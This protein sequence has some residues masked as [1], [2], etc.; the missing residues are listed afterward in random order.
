[1]KLKLLL[2][3]IVVGG[4]LFWAFSHDPQTIVDTPEENDVLPEEKKETYTEYIVQDDDTFT[5]AMEALGFGYSEALAMVSSSADVYDFTKIRIGKPFRLYTKDGEKIRLEYDVNTEEF[6]SVDVTSDDFVAVK[7]EIAYDVSDVHKKATINNSLYVSGLDAG[8]SEDIILTF[9]D[10]FGWTVDFATQVQEG[11]GFEIVY[12]KRERF[13][14]PAGDG[15]MLVG[16]FTNNGNTYRGYLF[17]D[18]EGKPAY[19]DEN[20]NS[21]VRA[22][23][24]APLEYKRISSGYTYARFH[25]WLGRA[26]KHLA[27]DYAAPMGTPIRAVA[28]GTIVTAR[29]NGGYGNF[30]DIKHGGVYKTQYAHLSRYGAG[31][32]PGAR[33]KQGQVIGYVGSTGFSTGP[34]LHYQI[35]KNGQR[36]NPLTV[37]LPPGDPV[38]EEKREAFEARKNELDALLQ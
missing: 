30:I 34:H 23:L 24:R 29:Y 5:S 35:E 37:E 36:V 10:A 4:G 7:A 26:T 33:V 9:A 18:D 17:E 15:R 8:M 11:D 21:M 12:E 27:I 1:M 28:D 38:V 13:G 22:F 16:T 20:G 3:L 2:V 6:V 19:Y 32:K 25:P 31:I 14:E